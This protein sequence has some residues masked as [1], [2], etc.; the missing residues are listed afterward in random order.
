MALLPH[1]VGLFQARAW[2]DDGS[3]SAAMVKEI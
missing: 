3:T 1:L 2:Y